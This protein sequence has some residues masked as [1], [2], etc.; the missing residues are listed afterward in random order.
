MLR[1]K[2]EYKVTIFFVKRKTLDN[3]V[4]T[5]LSE[6][7]SHAIK[8]NYMVK[9]DFPTFQGRLNLG[10]KHL[11]HQNWENLMQ[12]KRTG[13]TFFRLKAYTKLDA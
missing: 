8:S 3:K 1:V 9:S 12:S 4:F 13:P 6:S 2:P 5:S 10:K 7:H 11:N